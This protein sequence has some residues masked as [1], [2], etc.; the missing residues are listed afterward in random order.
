MI[1]LAG[2]CSAISIKLC[3]SIDDVVWLAPFLTS[4]SSPKFRLQN[5][6]IYTSIC[7]V[8]TL[9]AMILAYCGDAVV[10]W[11]TSNSKD[12]WSSDK[13]LTVSAGTM[14]SLYSIK[15]IYEYMTEGDDDEDEESRE[16]GSRNTGGK[17][18]DESPLSDDVELATK[19]FKAT[20]REIS[21][22]GSGSG[23]EAGHNGGGGGAHH[24]DPE[25]LEKER[26][27]TLFV[28]AY[29][30]SVD[31]L[32]LFV[33]MLVGKSFDLVQLISGALV[34]ASCIVAIC[35]FIGQCKPIA[36]CLSSIPLFAI[37]IAFALILVTKG[38][39]ME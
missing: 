5:A 27:M 36:D 11:L 8:Q 38:L 7:V 32:T 18:D 2:L 33:P 3:S 16:K 12:A 1:W 17:G 26:Q 15:L 23:M 9:T 19:P 22:Q 10:K 29:I 30:G 31:D 4:N 6:G 35:V 20:S 34:A 14:L 13:I 28:I 24:E 37:V 25:K 39:F 21:R